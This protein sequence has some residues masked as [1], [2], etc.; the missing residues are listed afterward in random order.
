[1]VSCPSRL[2]ELRIKLEVMTTARADAERRSL[3]LGT[4]SGDRQEEERAL[5]KQLGELELIQKNMH[6]HNEKNSY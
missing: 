4:E 5:R 3:L 1:M 6:L 2:Q